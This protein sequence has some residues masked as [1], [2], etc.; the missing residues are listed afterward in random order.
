MATKQAL[1]VDDSKSA[2]QVLTRM[3]KK[4][5]L[6]ADAAFSAEEAL[7]YLSHRQPAVIFLDENM[8]GMNGIETLKTNPT[9]QRP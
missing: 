1:I 7:A 6:Q 5:D 9:P 3:L 8:P 4:F 2:Q